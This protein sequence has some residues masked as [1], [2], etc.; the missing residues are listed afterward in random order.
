MGKGREER[1]HFGE[2]LGEGWT[3]RTTVQLLPLL[4][5]QG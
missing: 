1:L 3:S 5:G 4:N 2:K